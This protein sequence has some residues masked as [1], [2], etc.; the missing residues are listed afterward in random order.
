LSKYTLLKSTKTY[1]DVEDSWAKN[2]INILKGKGVTSDDELFSPQS[3]VT[4]AEF[5]GWIANAYGLSGEDIENDFKDLDKDSPYYEA[6]LAAYD[7]GIVSGKDD[8]S[9]DPNGEVSR[10]EMAVM[11]ANALDNFDTTVNPET[12]V[13]AQYETDMPDWAKDSAEKLLEN[14]VVEETYF[15]SADNVTKEEAASIIYNL[16][17]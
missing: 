13:L 3:N 14:G 6:V 12:T 8:G 4:R 5:A 17:R 15:G 7:Q 9:F 16:Y 1:S 2:E 10:E 11:I